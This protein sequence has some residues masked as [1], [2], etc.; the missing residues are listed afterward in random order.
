MRRDGA[1]ILDAGESRIRAL[2]SSG[3]AAHGDGAGLSFG[4]CEHGRGNPLAIRLTMQPDNIT[5]SQTGTGTKT[6]KSG[7][8]VAP[9]DLPKD[10]KPLEGVNEGPAEGALPR[11]SG[12]PNT[13]GLR[14]QGRRNVN[15]GLHS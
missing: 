6:D 1:K 5:P 2:D 4:K 7:K 11:T 3:R 9:Q 8:T 14:D 12:E 10:H 15:R 13:T